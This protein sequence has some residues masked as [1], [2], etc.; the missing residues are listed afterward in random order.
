M[1]IF[2]S[3]QMVSADKQMV[4]VNYSRVFIDFILNGNKNITSDFVDR[5]WIN[6]KLMKDVITRVAQDGLTIIE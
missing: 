4:P 3:L 1:V 5:F 6:T 2:V